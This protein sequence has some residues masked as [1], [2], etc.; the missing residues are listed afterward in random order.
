MKNT[1]RVHTCISKLE[2][3]REE[4]GEREIEIGRDREDNLKEGMKVM[5]TWRH[6]TIITKIYNRNKKDE[7]LTI[8]GN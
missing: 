1:G 7:K 3:E 8:N 4:R 5:Y 2:G 6:N